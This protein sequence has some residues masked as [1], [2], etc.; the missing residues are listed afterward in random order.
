MPNR[1]EGGRHLCGD[2]VATLGVV[3]RDE[4]DVVVDFYQYWI[5]HCLSLMTAAPMRLSQQPTSYY[6]ASNLCR[7]N[8]W[9]DAT[10]LERQSVQQSVQ[11]FVQHKSTLHP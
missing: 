10:A 2:G 4:G 5:G 11:H 3:D 1:A 9:Q 6:A 7:P 8:C